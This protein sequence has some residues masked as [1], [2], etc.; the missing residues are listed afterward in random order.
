MYKPVGINIE[1]AKPGMK[2]AKSVYIITMSGTPLLAARKE[3]VL[4]EV[5]IRM[6]ISKGVKNIDILEKKEAPESFKS[7]IFV[8]V[9]TVLGEKLKEDAL[10]SLREI[11]TCFGNTGGRVDKGAADECLKN[12]EG[13]VGDIVDVISAEDATLV[14][15]S[16]LKKFDEYTYHHS[17]SVAMLSITTGRELGLGSDELFRL[18]RCAMMHDIGKSLIPSN[19]LHKS[20]KLNYD[21][22]E[23]IKNHAA[24]G[25]NNLKLNN[26]GDDEMWNAIMYHHEKV[27]GTGYPKS[28]SAEE[29][30][31][32]AKI[33]SVADVYDAVTSFRAHRKP[34]LPTEALEIIRRGIG[35]DF[36]YTVVK[37][38]FSKLDSFPVNTIV[39]L[40]D[41]RIGF[42][43]ESKTPFRLRPSIRIWGTDE[44][45]PLASLADPHMKI[46]GVADSENMPTGY[47][48]GGK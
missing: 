33:I 16:D 18:G 43:V 26:V 35:R 8:P 12:V 1:D 32:F 37:A 42:V 19:I 9:E 25:A 3:A 15:I 48:F 36:D 13:V 31:L 10:D 46:A 17:L 23:T 20:E 45:I 44:V 34:M 21:E 11:F 6:L 39:E 14:H 47:V 29:I 7:E 30:P 5:T 4:D 24:L 40:S 2:L 22:F 38:F 41:G 28:L 27:N